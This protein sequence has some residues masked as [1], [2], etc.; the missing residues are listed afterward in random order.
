MF[1]I[2]VTNGSYSENFFESD[3]TI[4]RN[5]IRHLINAGWEV[6]VLYNATHTR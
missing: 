5:L 1:S 6:S 4:A 3:L 2:F